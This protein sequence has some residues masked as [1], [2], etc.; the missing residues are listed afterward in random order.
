MWCCP[1][2]TNNSANYNLLLFLPS[3]RRAS[4]PSP[5]RL[6]YT[7]VTMPKEHRILN[8]ALEFTGCRQ[9]CTL[10]DGMS[11]TS[12]SHRSIRL[13]NLLH[14]Y[15]RQQSRKR[16]CHGIAQRPQFRDLYPKRPMKARS[17]AQPFRKPYLLYT[18]IIATIKSSFYNWKSMTTLMMSEWVNL[19]KYDHTVGVWTYDRSSIHVSLDSFS[20][21]GILV[22]IIHTT[23]LWRWK[24][25]NK[26]VVRYHYFLP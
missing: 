24:Q 13:Q 12:S 22:L 10:M 21:Y 17:T 4:L 8:R 16:E 20:C 15:P 19:N 6:P 18:V 2:E 7:P 1:S 3:P 11:R 23:F 14:L 25:E 5:P 26:S 9:I